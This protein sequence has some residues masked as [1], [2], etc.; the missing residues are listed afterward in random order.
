[1]HASKTIILATIFAAAISLV[2]FTACSAQGFGRVQASLKYECNPETNLCRQYQ[3]FG[4]KRDVD[5]L[6]G[7]RTAILRKRA[8]IEQVKVLDVAQAQLVAEIY[9]RYSKH[10]D[11]LTW[12][13]AVDKHFET[14]TRQI[15]AIDDAIGIDPGD[16]KKGILKTIGDSINPFDGQ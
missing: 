13:E 16:E 3:D 9:N 11:V 12:E 6:R 10:M 14:W 7:E 2:P 1:M 4:E 5:E 15:Q 8:Y